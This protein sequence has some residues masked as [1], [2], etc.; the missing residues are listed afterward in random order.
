MNNLRYQY[1][2][3]LWLNQGLYGFITRSI[4][5]SRLQQNMGDTINIGISEDEEDIDEDE[6]YD[7][8]IFLRPATNEDRAW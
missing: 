5:G 6:E 1:L 8:D 3:K 4:F 7:D 2:N